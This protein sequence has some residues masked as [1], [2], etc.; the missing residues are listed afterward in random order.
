MNLEYPLTANN[1]IILGQFADA[2][3]ANLCFII[4]IAYLYPSSLPLLQC[5]LTNWKFFILE[6]LS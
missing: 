2:Y 4:H 6:D 1:P 5:I 3:Q